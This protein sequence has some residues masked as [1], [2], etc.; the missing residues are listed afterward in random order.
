MGVSVDINSGG[1][2]IAIGANTNNGPNGFSSGLARV[3]E[4][5]GTS[6]VQV[7][8]DLNGEFFGDL[9]GV[10]VSLNASGNKLAVELQ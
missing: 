8:D 7:G 4:W 1:D 5:D 9:F 6:W 3:F 2:I 10:S